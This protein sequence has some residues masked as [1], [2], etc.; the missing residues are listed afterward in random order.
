MSD[1][2][3]LPR[4][5]TVEII[6]ALLFGC[7]LFFF[8]IKPF[9]DKPE[10]INRLLSNKQEL[11]IINAAYKSKNNGILKVV[12]KNTKNWLN[13]NPNK[14]NE[15]G[16]YEGKDL[17]MGKMGMSFSINPESCLKFKDTMN[18]LSADF[19]INN[20]KVDKNIN[21]KDIRGVAD[22]KFI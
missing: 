5:F 1:N 18:Y 15:A 17:S 22:I 9:N 6:L 19:L 12:L 3:N 10:D 11:N 21:C 16:F 7:F 8:V 14:F 20:K 13:V 4:A 2:K